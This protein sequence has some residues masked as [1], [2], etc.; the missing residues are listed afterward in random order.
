M[1]SL[2]SLCIPCMNRTH[3]LKIVMPSIIT[4]ANAGAPVEIAILDYNSQDDLAEYVANLI[5]S[6][7][8]IGGSTISYHQ[9]RGR[10]YYHMAHARNLSVLA[11]RGNY[12][13][14][15]SADIQVKPHFFEAIRKYIE[16][17]N[18]TWLHFKNE[19]GVITVRRS[20]FIEAGGFDERFEFYGSE[21]KDLYLR[22]LRRAGRHV[23]MPHKLFHSNYTPEFMKL[24]NYRV[25][26]TKAEMDARGKVIYFENI[27]AGELVANPNGWGSWT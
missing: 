23:I 21:D 2:I 5:H 19:T 20:E 13:V 3:D 25:R 1:R 18:P 6:T 11:S 27:Q 22:L 4:A 9:F 15:S 17:E 16:Q 8:M 24:E 14:I 7:P 12:V 10:D 26:L